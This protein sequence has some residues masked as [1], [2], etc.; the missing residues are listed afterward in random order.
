MR[1]RCTRLED[2]FLTLEGVGNWTALGYMQA[3]EG[4]RLPPA[5]A[6]RRLR[7]DGQSWTQDEGLAL[8]LVLDALVPQW[9]RR[10]L[11]R[12]AISGFAL[13]SEAAR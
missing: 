12:E 3:P 8:F 10:V 2:V 5:D 9:Q 6:M 13:L 1:T 7:G 11:A 4:L